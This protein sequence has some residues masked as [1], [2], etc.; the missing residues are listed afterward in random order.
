M[1]C[2]IV[3][4]S[5]WRD[6]GWLELCLAAV[7]RFC[8]G[9]SQVIV[10]IPNASEPWLRRRAALPPSV[11]LE[12]CR[13]YDDDYLGQQVTKLY[14]DRLSEAGLICHLDSDCIVQKPIT[15]NDLTSDGRPRIY[16]RAVADLPRHW[17]WT[18][19]TAEFLGWMPT[20]D[21]MQNPPFTFPR[22]LYPKIR[23]WSRREKGVPLSDWVMSRPARGFSE[24]NVLAAY[25]HEYHREAFEWIPIDQLADTDRSCQWFWSWGGLDADIRQLI[26]RILQPVSYG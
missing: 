19:P 6:F 15:P 2:D 10:V 7:E 14:A 8:S 20:H 26:D 18:Q 16:T 13:D 21:F 25:A 23:A 22:W 3:I 9:F 24:F 4:R 1:T 5:Y 11:R 17:P 12:L